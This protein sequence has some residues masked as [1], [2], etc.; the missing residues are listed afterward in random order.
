MARCI[1]EIIDAAKGAITKKE[2][3]A[4]VKSIERKFNQPMPKKP[5][6]PGESYGRQSGEKSPE[7]RML[8]AAEE[9]F[10]E[11]VAKKQ[12]AAR[13]KELQIE[14]ANRLQYQIV[15]K[16]TEGGFNKALT[17]I[18]NTN[19][20]GRVKAI[21]EQFMTELYRGL[22]PFL[23]KIGFR[24][25]KP[26]EELELAR[27][28]M[29]EDPA[30]KAAEFDP[31][32][33]TETE[34]LAY[35]YRVASNMAF[36]RAN[37][38]GADIK[39]LGGRIPQRW[40]AMQVK[41]FGMSGREKLELAA[42]GVSLA[43]RKRLIARASEKW[44]EF[45]LPRLNRD[46]Y[47]DPETGLP[48]NDEQLQEMLRSVWQ[49]LATRGLSKE[50]PELVQG[51]GAALAEQLGAH[52]ELHFKDAESWLE[53]N[54]AFG[55][56]D[57]Y[58]A[59]TGD[60][61]NKAQAIALM[62]EFGPNPETGFRTADAYAKSQ[63]AQLTANGRE[64]S[65]INALMFAELMGKTS[66]APEDRFD[67]INKFMQGLRNYITA[68]KMG[69]L[70]LSQV[71]DIATFRAIAQ[72]DGLDTGRAFRVALKMLDPTNHADREIARKNAI[73]AQSV[74]NEVGFRYGME[75]NNG[76][77]RKLANWTVTLTGAEHWTNAMK[78]AFQTLIGSHTADYRGTLYDKLEP[79]FKQMLDRYDITETE[80]DIIR[81]AQH[82]GLAG[83]DV[84]TPYAVKNVILRGGGMEA[85]R[86]A[87][88]ADLD[89]RRAVQEAA[90]KYG[91]MLAE[92]ADTGMLTP[93]VHTHAWINQKTEPGT[94][95]GEAARSFFLF[96][97]FSIAMLTRALPRIFAEGAG[98]SRL[99]IASQWS[100]GMVVGGALSMQL[101][102]IAKGR[103]PRDM[104]DPAFWGA[105]ALQSGG[106]GIF[107]D[108]L[109]QDANR[110]GG[111]IVN[112]FIGPVGGFAT[113]LQKL[114]VGNAE[115]AADGKDTKFAS[116][117]IQFAKNY[118]PLLNLWYTRL[119]ID[120]ALL[121]QVQEAAN[122]GYLRRMRQRTEH[123]NNQG[124]WWSPEDTLPDAPPDLK[125]AF[126]GNR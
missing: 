24:K 18:I 69:M 120:H 93:D 45:T 83:V 94:F 36:H 2:A 58:Q 47:A 25:L 40:D 54:R 78:Q 1:K 115:Q 70:L 63:Q 103:N 116:E 82:V 23:S 99:A 14:V 97:T 28:M 26:E 81:Q 29:A 22:E 90:T 10:Q 20:S 74:V 42:P 8:D 88:Q 85:G 104:A 98:T 113:D 65:T 123:E 39:Y 114:T 92:E 64:G 7:R 27:Q 9:A 107:G 57:L 112:T 19:V 11:A 31:A 108:F 118:T 102:D 72:T 55:S 87:A 76:M 33:M 68:A 4:I 17:E 125:Q 67:T 12:E 38:A 75:Q 111:G 91:A 101:K 30:G 62:E 121:F 122:P 43:R 49:T 109:L 89:A 48:L 61:R 66:H 95:A 100:L 80:W 84:I 32:R 37:D 15:R 53:A 21:S 35:Q 51:K 117:A 16:T 79:A 106:M 119:A 41:Q 3:E 52:R 71:N 44:V 56:G 6:Q 124:F 13:R 46:K 73:L 86:K 5:L 50:P 60:L 59:M 126:G 96:K 77:S 110:F 34:Y 105:A